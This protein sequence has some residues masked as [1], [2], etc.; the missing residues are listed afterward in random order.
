MVACISRVF[1]DIKSH[2]LLLFVCSGLPLCVSAEI[3]MGELV[4]THGQCGLVTID[5]G[6]WEDGIPITNIDWQW[7]DGSVNNAQFPAKHEYEANGD[8]EII[9]TANGHT[10]ATRT[11]QIA[12][13]IDNANDQG[14][15]LD[16]VI[17]PWQIY[18]RD[19]VTQQ[20]ILVEAR[21]EEGRVIDPST[22][23]FNYDIS[24]DEIG[25]LQVTPQGLVSASGFGRGVIHVV[26]QP[27]GRTMD[28]LVNAGHIRTTPMF[29]YLSVNGQSSGSVRPD[30]ANADGSPVDIN[31][32]DVD[33]RCSGCATGQPLSIDA[34]GNLQV[35][36]D[37]QPGDPAPLSVHAVVDGQ[38]AEYAAIIHVSESDLG[39]TLKE[40]VTHNT[41]INSVDGAAGF[42][43]DAIIKGFLMPELFELGYEIQRHLIFGPSWQ[44]ARQGAI[45]YTSHSRFGGVFPGC[46]GSGQPIRM[47]TNMDDPNL[48]C[49]FYTISEGELSPKWGTVFHELGHNMTFSSS[50]FDQFA[51]AG[52]GFIYSEG[53]ATAVGMYTCEALLR[54]GESIGVTEKIA[55]TLNGSW[56]CWHHWEV[57]KSLSDYIDAGADYNKMDPNII[58][59]ILSQL[60][61]EFDYG[62]IYRLFGMFA[63]RGRF[64]WPFEFATPEQQATMF[65]VGCSVASGVDLKA[66]FRDDWGFPINDATWDRMYP[67]I[68]QVIKARYPAS[69]AGADKLTALGTPITLNDAFVFDRE[70]DE[71]TLEWAVISKPPKATAV[72]SDASLLNPIFTTDLGGKYILS[73]RASDKWAQGEPDTVT[74]NVI[75]PDVIFFSSFE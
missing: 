63:P 34:D 25:D 51:G 26:L 58:D 53:L 54:A 20:Q 66:R 45:N 8:Y 19:G 11:E 71:L 18:L 60:V 9:L 13:Q 59:D 72:F 61:N 24:L 30:I 1:T 6:A 56:L 49:F 29:Q 17:H 47:G 3:T 28:V 36:E 32:H 23:N 15:E 55:Q 43:F 35:V 57:G 64:D 67:V 50:L 12:V 38:Q 70:Q 22:L 7:G 14:C 37:W 33:F 4:V 31:G 16:L 39:L 10:G 44:V 2:G 52:D 74:I 73:L 69:N 48:S 46:G 75:D 42:D 68:E 65:A 40:Y 21:D 27:G 5:A 41:I 62:L